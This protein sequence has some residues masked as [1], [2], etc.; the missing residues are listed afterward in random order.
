MI[1]SNEDSGDGSQPTTGS[2]AGLAIFL[3]ALV[4]LLGMAAWKRENIRD[5]VRREILIRQHSGADGLLNPN[6][7]E[8]DTQ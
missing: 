6:Y 8:N 5:F 1:C 7:N 3:I 4:V 2:Q